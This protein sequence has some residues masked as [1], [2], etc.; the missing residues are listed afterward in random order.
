MVE[1]GKRIVLG[2]RNE[3]GSYRIPVDVAVGVCQVI[4]PFKH[5]PLVPPS[6]H[7]IDTVGSARV[8]LRLTSR[9]TCCMIS[10]MLPSGVA[11]KIWKWFDIR[12][13]EMTCA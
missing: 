8:I 2:R 12:T 1:S 10:L 9:I 11:I 5:T 4:L 7:V 3:M 13:N 6:E